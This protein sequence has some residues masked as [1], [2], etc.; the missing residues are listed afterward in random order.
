[1]AQS[2]GFLYAGSLSVAASYVP[3]LT[4]PATLSR[5]FQLA[6]GLYAGETMNEGKAPA[7]HSRHSPGSMDRS[8]GETLAFSPVPGLS[9]RGARAV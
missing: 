2:L 1:M 7:Q 4:T 5:I 3:C 6:T 9:D 8:T